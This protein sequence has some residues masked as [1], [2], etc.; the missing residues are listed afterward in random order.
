MAAV[1][2]RSL[3][4]TVAFTSV[5]VLAF[6][7]SL[8]RILLQAS[9]HHFAFVVI[10]IA[11]IGFGASGTALFILQRPILKHCQSVLFALVLATG[12]SMPMCTSLAQHIPIESRLAPA[13]L[14]WQIGCWVSYWAVLAIPFFLGA[15]AIGLGLMTARD[16]VAG[17]YAAN[18]LGSACGALLA[19][20]VMF[21]VEAQWLPYLTGGAVVIG[22]VTVGG[23]W[24]GKSVVGW[25]L[26]VSMVIFCAVIDPP[27]VR[28]DPYKRGAQVQR[29]ERQGQVERIT[30]V[31]GPRGKVEFFRSH[32]FHDLPFLS[33]ST[34]PPPM[35]IILSDG[36]FAGSVLEVQRTADAAVVDHTIMAVPYDL[37]PD[38]PDVL[39]LGEAGGT[40]VWLAALH[41]AGSTHLVQPDG[42][43]ISV[44]QGQPKHLGSAFLELPGVHAVIGEPRHF[45]DRTKERFDLIQLVNLESSAAGSGGAAG[46][47]QNYLITVEGFAS[48]LDRLTAGGIIAVSRGIQD[49][50]RDNI[51]LLATFVAALR[52]RGIAD[53]QDHVAIVRDYLAVCTMVTRSPLE[54][55]H[56]EALRRACSGRQLTP[57]WFPGIQ[58]SELNH[59]D[60]LPVGPDEVGDWYYYAASQLF[61][62]D[63]ERFIDG[64]S[65][66]IRPPTDDRPFFFDFCRL[67]AIGALRR[68]FGELWLT[69]TEVALLFVLAAGTVIVVVGGIMTLAPLLAIRRKEPTAAKGWVAAYFA[70]IG[71]AY[72]LL[73]LA[74][75]SRLIHWIG[76]PLTAAAV[77]IAGLLLF[78]GLGSLTVQR[79]KLSSPRW[80]C[81][82]MLCLITL[83]VGESMVFRRYANVVGSLSQLTGCA[84]AL[85]PIAPLGFLMG[86]PMPTALLRL[87][88]AAAQPVN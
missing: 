22:A 55:N 18:L 85:L 43:V 83:A 69:R 63:A 36:H 70:S 77:T 20:G 46:L 49:P 62:P 14:W 30:G 19:P 5:G 35:G 84:A 16:H 66:D 2:T 71:L 38:Q 51:K 65:F 11:L 8:M 79:L 41:E 88:R 86:F 80:V 61:S 75:L 34:P 57:V 28:P 1:R 82:L 10:S 56:I 52:T 40:N 25:L 39:L 9:W 68:A 44:L 27:H 47:A 29:L 58:P 4:W 42:H 48:C 59:P 73:E 53:P 13:L 78:S 26:C 17:T 3:Q 37:L 21:V 7:I 64:W 32:L 60:A 81:C 31:C 23:A 72:L 45:V 6:E 54:P 74:L 24:T 67:R 76:D 12:S 33:G 50:P 87:G 15:A